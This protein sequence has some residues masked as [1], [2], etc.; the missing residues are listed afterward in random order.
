MIATTAEPRIVTNVKLIINEELPTELRSA[1]D[2]AAQANDMTVNDAAS[3][4]LADHFKVEWN[5][6]GFAY[7][8]V[9]LRFKLRVSDDLHKVLRVHAAQK[10]YTIRGLA[11]STLSNHFRTGEISPH[12]RP[13]SDADV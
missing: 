12:R 9:A 13:R 3:K 10:L 7:R 2:K 11:L 6:S 4:V 1:L 8:P 5:Q